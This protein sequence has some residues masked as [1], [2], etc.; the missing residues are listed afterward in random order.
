M[1]S[2][3]ILKQNKTTGPITR[4]EIQS[5]LVK[6]EIN[7]ETLAQ[8]AIGKAHMDLSRWKPLRC[9]LSDVNLSPDAFSF[10]NNDIDASSEKQQIAKLWN[11]LKAEQQKLK[12]ISDS[13]HSKIRKEREALHSLELKLKKQIEELE[14]TRREFEE[15]RSQNH[16]TSDSASTSNKKS[17]SAKEHAMTLRLNGQV[18]TDEI[19]KAYKN[20]A[21]IF[22]PDAL[23]GQNALL[24]S[25][26]AEHFKEIN[27]SYDYFR[28]KYNIK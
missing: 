20:L 12:E 11:E 24:V 9:F 13:E 25:L 15:E 6:G 19:K 18:T 8:Q 5:L 4:E 17:K 28:R 16:K 1:K 2:F 26:A 3:Y 27:N 10:R 23:S 7:D 14:K 21:R 22:H